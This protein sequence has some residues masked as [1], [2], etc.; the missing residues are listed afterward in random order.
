VFSI[1]IQGRRDAL[2][3]MATHGLA[4]ATPIARKPTVGQL[5]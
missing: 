2:A 3:H 5:G 1:C 4:I